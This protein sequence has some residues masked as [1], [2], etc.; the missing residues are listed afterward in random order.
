[1]KYDSKAIVFIKSV[2]EV[3][4]FALVVFMTAIIMSWVFVQTYE[5]LFKPL[6][7]DAATMMGKPLSIDLCDLANDDGLIALT[8]VSCLEVVN[9]YGEQETWN[10]QIVGRNE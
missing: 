4:G 2:I 7:V 8:P 10:P 9:N 1:M 5:L 3:I 6:P